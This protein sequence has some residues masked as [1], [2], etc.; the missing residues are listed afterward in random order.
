[1]VGI[2]IIVATYN[3][4]EDTFELINSINNSY[5]NFKKDCKKERLSF[6]LIIADNSTNEQTKNLIN[7]F[8]FPYLRYFKIPP[9]GCAYARD[10]AIKRARYGYIAITDADCIVHKDWL[11]QIFLLIKNNRSPDAI[12][13]AY[14]YPYNKDWFSKSESKWDK[15]RYAEG[16]ADT[17]N[18]IIKKKIYFKIGGFDIKHFYAAGAE[19]LIL[20]DRIKELTN[21]NVIFNKNIVIYHKYPKL[22]G[23]LKR[24]LFYGKACIHI[25]KYYKDKFKDFSP[26]TLWKWFLLRIGH[27]SLLE[28]SYQFIKL[29]YFTV[30]YFIGKKHYSLEKNKNKIINPKVKI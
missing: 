11:K 26:P 29:I 8:K 6:E 17:R 10:Y 7:K 16:Q 22:S 23:E 30:G 19:D 25:K 15:R 13:G 20:L 3:V 4:P 14:F 5:K 2:S 1:M 12:Q 21:S 24:Y 27:T 28:I 18:F 9:L